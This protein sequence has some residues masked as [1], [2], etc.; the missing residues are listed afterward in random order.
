MNREFV[1][2]RPQY[3]WIERIYTEIIILFLPFLKKTFITPNM[4]TALNLIITLPLL[5][6]SA[7]FEKYYTAAILIQVYLF[8]DILDGNLARYKNLCSDFGKKLDKATDILFYTGFYIILGYRVG[9]SIYTIA[10]FIFVFHLYGITATFYI[11]PK[12]R[13]LTVVRRWGLKKILFEK[14]FL[15]GMDNGM[16]DVLMTIFLFTPYRQ[17]PFYISMVLY[18]IDMCYR[19]IELGRNQEIE[20]TEGISL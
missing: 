19:L 5:C 16:Q 18:I 1:P 14:G 3:Y 20:K 6:Y 2:K 11:V 12:L 9:L 8:I 15:F 10:A 4:V 17:A 13:K 7:W